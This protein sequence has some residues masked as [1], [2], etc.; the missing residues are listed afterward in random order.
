MSFWDNFS[1]DPE[2]PSEGPSF[3]DNF[4]E[5]EAPNEE[6]LASVQTTP[7]ARFFNEKMIFW[8]MRNLPVKEALKHFLACGAIGSGKTTTIDLFLQSFARRFHRERKQPEQLII[9]DAKGDTIPKL[10]ALGYPPEDENVW[11]INPYDA[12]SAIWNV[13]EAVESPLMAR[14][15]AALLVPEEPASTTP[16]FWTASRQLVY[17]TILALGRIAGNDWSL[18]DLLCA[19]SSRERITA[20]TAL[21]PRAKE[22]TS[23]V[24]NDGVNSHGVISSLATKIGALEQVAALWH[25]A[26]R[27]RKFSIS[28]FLKRPGVLILGNDPVLRESL[29]PINAMLLKSLG[30]EILRGP[31]VQE[32]KHWFVLDE[33]PAMEKADSIHELLSQGRSKGASVLIG[34]QGIDRLKELYGDNG[35]NDL[36]EQCSSKTFFRAG[37]PATAEWVER[38]FGKYRRMEPVY[39]ES[40]TEKQRTISVQYSMAERS[41]FLASFFMNLPATG[42]GLPYVAVSDVPCLQTTLI[43]RRHFDEINFWR[44]K[45][46]AKVPALIPRNKF[47]DQTLKPWTPDEA[48]DFH[49][50]SKAPPPAPEAKPK[51][52]KLPNRKPKPGEDQT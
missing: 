38:F 41:I 7:C 47:S 50:P 22:L 23:A 35:A 14:H 2:E 43:T 4:T 32:P 46:D 52:P 8:A 42:P 30:K 40:W 25:T 44:I 45:P 39:S 24:L 13:A 17:A 36:L 9:F 6:V 27:K 5:A 18:R 19:L 26:P 29:W 28:E 48:E 33:F 37:G 1:E 21:H 51:K 10:A 12:R 3:W 34:L 20:I 11:I 49:G 16:Y 31:E 15:F